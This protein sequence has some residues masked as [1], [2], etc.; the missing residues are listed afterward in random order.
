MIKFSKQQLKVPKLMRPVYLVTAGQSK[1]DRAMPDKRTEE[2]CVDAFTMA[3]DLLNMS[4]A[5]LKQYIHTCYYGHFAD[6]FGDQLLGEAVIHDRLGLD[7]LGNVGSKDRR[8]NRRFHALGGHEGSCFRIFG[9][10]ARHGLGEDG[11][12]PHG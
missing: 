11:R 2:L 6:H 1:F 9:L 4:A 5:E 12:G 3:S 7:P 8:R 10:C